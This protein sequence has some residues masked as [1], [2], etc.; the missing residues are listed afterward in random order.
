MGQIRF[1]YAL[2]LLTSFIGYVNVSGAAETTQQSKKTNQR[3]LASASSQ[4]AAP[5]TSSASGFSSAP[6]AVNQSIGAHGDF[7]R[8]SA[9]S[10]SMNA[11]KKPFAFI[12]VLA[13]LPNNDTV[14]N[15]GFSLNEGALYFGKD[16]S[17]A[18]AFVDL[19]FGPSVN[20]TDRSLVF[21]HESSQ[22]HIQYQLESA[23][24][25]LGQYDS[26]FGVEAEDS[27]DRFFASQGSIATFLHPSTHTGVMVKFKN[28]DL[29]GRVQMA[30]PN[31]SPEVGPQNPELGAQLRLERGA[32]YGALGLSVGEESEG[33][34]RQST[35]VDLMFGLVSGDGEFQFDFDVSLRKESGVDRQVVGLGAYGNY[36]V[37]DS[38]T[39][40]ARFESLN[41]LQ[42]IGRLGGFIERITELSVGPS[43]RLE[44]G[45]TFRGDLTYSSIK[46]TVSEQVTYLLLASAV[47]DF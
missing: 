40:G 33:I 42:G 31:G 6:G 1:V 43:Y 13:I 27:R 29:I 24:L 7:S 35:L 10:P 21:S 32:G 46:S 36:L 44:P 5:V 3:K 34:H 8:T 25:T 39:W 16:F 47:A 22:A 11:A 9:S 2:V 30:N 17:R 26:F 18:S 15:R 37:N 41:N 4:S 38:L 28:G 19:S 23:V 12:D 45:L 14:P 20:L